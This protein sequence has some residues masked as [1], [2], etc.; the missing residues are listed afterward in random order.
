MEHR[1]YPLALG[2]VAAGKVRVAGETTIFDPPETARDA[3]LL[4]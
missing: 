2:L 1:L 4:G 3:L